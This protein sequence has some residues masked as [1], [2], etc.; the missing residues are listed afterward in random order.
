[1]LAGAVLLLSG[2]SAGDPV[3]AAAPSV[4]EDFS[5]TFEVESP[6]QLVAGVGQAWLLRGDDS[7]VA[8]STIAH[9]GRI[10]EVRRLPGQ[11]AGMA[12][13]RD[14]VVVSRL[15]CDAEECEATAVKV[16]ALDAAGDTVAEGEFDREFGGLES[17]GEGRGAELMGVLDDIAWVYTGGQLIGY[18][19]TTGRTSTAEPTA[20]GAVTC[21]LADGLY[22]L[23]VVD[24]DYLAGDIFIPAEGPGP[25]FDVEIQRLVDTTWAPVPD[26]RRSLT[27]DEIY[28]Q[29]CTGGGVDAG[30]GLEPGPVWSSFSGWVERGPHLAPPSLTVAPEPTA[31]G[32]GDQL[33]VLQ[34]AGVVRRW[35]AGPDG[36][37][38]SQTVEVPADIFVQPFGPVVHMLFDA[39]SSAAVGC[40]QQSAASPAAD[41][42]IGSVDE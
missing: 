33:F 2:C 38:S 6:G 23:V 26:S 9:T 7:G 1:M 10:D 37:M 8:L 16:L 24:E 21:V 40:V 29:T 19:L 22:S 12:P 32:Q 4:P 13:Y 25:V 35:F 14:G 17:D 36:P 3:E 5:A 39:S 31:T 11:G 30:S 41:C 42:W 15:A 18:D 28:W 27:Y 20:P 34:Q